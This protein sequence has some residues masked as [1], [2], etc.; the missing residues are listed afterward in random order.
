MVNIAFFGTITVYP[1]NS[2]QTEKPV[3]MQYGQHENNVMRVI[4]I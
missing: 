2:S 4:I 3:K 1:K